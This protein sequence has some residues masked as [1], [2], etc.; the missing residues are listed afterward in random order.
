[1]QMTRKLMKLCEKATRL[2]ENMKI[3]RL[4]ENTQ[5]NSMN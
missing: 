5:G 3:G 4:G 2:P 1:M